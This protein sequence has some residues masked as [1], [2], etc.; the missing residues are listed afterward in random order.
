MGE[1]KDIFHADRIEGD[2]NQGNISRILVES[3][4][5]QQLETK[6]N[7]GNIYMMKAGFEY[8]SGDMGGRLWWRLSA[9]NFVKNEGGVLCMNESETE[10]D[11]QEPQ[12][13]SR[14]KLRI[15]GRGMLNG[16]DVEHGLLELG[17]F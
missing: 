16:I 15:S 1:G 12:L 5:K 11:I 17:Q 3:C 10:L 2:R 9:H 13:G 7:A 4:V 6:M 8:R 14:M